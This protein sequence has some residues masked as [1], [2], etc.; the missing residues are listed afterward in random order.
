MLPIAWFSASTP[1]FCCVFGRQC[2]CLLV[3]LFLT[4]GLLLVG[5]SV[6]AQVSAQPAPT[7]ESQTLLQESRFSAL[8]KQQR[9][10][11]QSRLEVITPLLAN[12]Q[13]AQVGGLIIEQLVD[14]AQ[15]QSALQ[16]AG[17]ITGRDVRYTLVYRPQLASGKGSMR[18]TLTY[19]DAVAGTDL[20]YNVTDGF[21]QGKARPFDV[22]LAPGEM[23]LFCILP[24]QMEGVEGSAK[25]EGN[26][27]QYSAR[28]FSGASDPILGHLPVAVV[29]Q[30]VSGPARVIAYGL[31]D[32]KG[33]YAGS[34]IQK[35]RERLQAEKS[36]L[37]VRSLLGDFEYAVQLSPAQGK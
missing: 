23:L 8:V 37:Y 2:R 22:T 20:I 34:L 17:L 10:E 21:L 12:K 27:W 5:R 19:A 15:Q 6:T 9:A 33:S 4:G 16:T 35:E 1:A 24:F 31:T 13:I 11:R 32:A 14:P 3:P 26:R 7:Q 29:E 28:F 18:F 25:R 30:P 36:K